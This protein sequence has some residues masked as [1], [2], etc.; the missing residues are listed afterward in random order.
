VRGFSSLSHLSQKDDRTSKKRRSH[1]P[2]KADRT[3][4]KKAVGVGEASVLAESLSVRRIAFPQ[5]IALTTEN[6]WY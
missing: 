1:F 5:A 2:K 3:S 6:R 4:P